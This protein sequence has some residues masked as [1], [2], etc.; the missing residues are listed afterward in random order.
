M[1]LK[2]QMLMD[3]QTSSRKLGAQVHGDGAYSRLQEG[4]GAGAGQP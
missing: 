4:G 3:L 2:E 1:P